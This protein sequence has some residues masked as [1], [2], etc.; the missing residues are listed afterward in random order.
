MT[1][2]ASIDEMYCRL[3]GRER[4]PE[5]AAELARKVK[6]AI[7]AQVGE[8]LRCSVGLGPNR[9]LAKVAADMH[10]PDGLTVIRPDGTDTFVSEGRPVATISNVMVEF[11][12]GPPP[13]KAPAKPTA[14]PPAK[15]P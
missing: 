13:K 7:R 8:A 5:V 4:Q 3:T 12:P 10:K 15:K 14:K 2:V 11:R 1:T 6:R 9:L